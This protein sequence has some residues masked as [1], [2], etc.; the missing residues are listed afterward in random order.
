MAN[1]QEEPDCYSDFFLPAVDV[2]HPSTAGIFFIA[3]RTNDIQAQHNPFY[4]PPLKNVHLVL[5]LV[6]MTQT[7]PR[8]P[9][10][11]TARS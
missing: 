2:S 11:P 8:T 9:S 7:K 6:K 10:F 3:V 5:N 4:E 1:V